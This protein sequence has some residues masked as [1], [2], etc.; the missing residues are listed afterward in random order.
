MPGN[1][2]SGRKKLSAAEKKFRGTFDVT[3]DKEQA[4]VENILL[5]TSIPENTEIQ[6]PK[7][8]TDSYVIDAYKNQVSWLTHYNQLHNIDLAELD[9]MFI[10][11]Q[12]LR[13]VTKKRLDVESKGVIENLEEYSRLSQIEM[14][15]R[16]QFID[17]GKDFMMTPTVRS[18]LTIEQLTADKMIAEK[19]ERENIIEDLF[20]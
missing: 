12:Q 10:T 2:N 16:K 14:K 6:P 1:K 5:P 3:R 8:I 19:K 18:K 13:T 7:I 15:L 11:L 17:M 4:A 20:K 9:E